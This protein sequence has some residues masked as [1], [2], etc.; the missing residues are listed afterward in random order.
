MLTDFSK[1]AVSVFSRVSTAAART[2]A[3]AWR[4]GAGRRRRAERGEEEESRERPERLL[5]RNP[6]RE[7]RSEEAAGWEMARER[8]VWERVR[9]EEAAMVEM[10]E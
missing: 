5:R 1:R 6:G 3:L 2:G 9:E 7:S 8:R 4:A 10:E